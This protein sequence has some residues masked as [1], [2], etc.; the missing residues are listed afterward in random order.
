MPT[1]EDLLKELELKSLLDQFVKITLPRIGVNYKQLPQKDFFGH[2][3]SDF[4][5]LILFEVSKICMNRTI[6]GQYY[7]NL[8]FEAFKHLKSLIKDTQDHLVFLH[9]LTL[10]MRHLKQNLENVYALTTKQIPF[11]ELYA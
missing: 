6:T 5:S 3:Y 9:N 8:L 11:K 10:T 2:N 7:M 4:V 1:V